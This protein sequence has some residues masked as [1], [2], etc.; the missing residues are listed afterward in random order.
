MVASRRESYS[1]TGDLTMTENQKEIW[2]PVI[3]FSGYEVSNHGRVRSWMS[4]NYPRKILSP[5]KTSTGYMQ[6]SLALN[7]VMYPVRVHRLVLIAFVGLCPEGMES[8]HKDGNRS[9][10]FLYNLRWG[11]KSSN[12]QDRHEHNTDNTGTKNGRATINEE[13]VKQI[14]QMASEGKSLRSIERT[15]NLPEAVVSK[16]VHRK[17][18]KHV[19]DQAVAP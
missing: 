4:I 18:W 8:C 14:R 9:N 5:A 13:T 3:G 17:T 16:V 19:A 1:F 6:V 10:N 12:Y 2:K 7:G 11:T 15:L